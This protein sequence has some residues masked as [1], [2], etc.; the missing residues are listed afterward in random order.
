MMVIERKTGKIENK[1]F[2]DILDYFDD[3]DVFVKVLIHKN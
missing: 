3:K 2:K 1:H